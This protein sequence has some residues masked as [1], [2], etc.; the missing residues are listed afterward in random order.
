MK[1][2]VLIPAR[3]AE[4]TLGACLDSLLA[5][6]VPP[7]R[8]IVIDD[9]STDGTAVIVE[10]RAARFG[11]RLTLIRSKRRLNVAG[12]RNAGLN[13]AEGDAVFFLDAD[14]EADPRWLEMGLAA[15]A[16]G[17]VG[18]RGRTSYGESN[19]GPRDRII[20]T[21][22]EST[23]FNTCNIAYRADTLRS[24]GGF[25]ERFWCG[26]EDTD[27][28]FRALE[29]GEI[30]YDDGMRVRHSKRLWTARQ[31]LDDAARD[32]VEV[33]FL[34]TWLVDRR[35]LLTD[36]QGRALADYRAGS[37]WGPVLYPRKLA[38]ALFPP[39]VLW[40]YRPRSIADALHLPLCWLRFALKR[41]IYW[42]GA[43]RYRVA[44]I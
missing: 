40:R 38:A 42:Y 26:R 27:L 37:S 31:I 35:G 12:A 1:A 17:A 25:D 28:A 16:D 8:V 24:L 44:V 19:P 4:K 15:F 41:L 20:E 6:T 23:Y 43:L 13:V 32:L 7:S 14:C 34:R 30:D 18:V 36:R 11:E 33:F 3:N 29:L 22:P 5:Q 10:R 39:A 21:G 9:A 2:C